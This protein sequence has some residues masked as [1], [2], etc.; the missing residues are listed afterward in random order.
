MTS[1]EPNWHPHRPGDPEAEP[2]KPAVRWVSVGPID[3]MKNWRLHSIFAWR[4][5]A[6]W[7]FS[8]NPQDVPTGECWQCVIDPPADEPEAEL[9]PRAI[10]VGDEVRHVSWEERGTVLAIAGGRAAVLW[11]E[12]L[13]AHS[14]R[15]LTLA[16][17]KPK[18]LTDAVKLA[19]A[20]GALW[21]AVDAYGKPGGPWNV[22]SDPGGW[23]NRATE[24]IAKIEG[25]K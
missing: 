9:T 11:A 5:G 23:L 8:G 6:T 25:K 22:P 18:P 3:P 12:G 7:Q 16:K 1:P 2:A 4:L 14:L 20:V 13:G 19:I 10:Q 17:P 15:Y 21:E 24:A